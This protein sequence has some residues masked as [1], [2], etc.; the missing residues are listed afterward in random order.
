MQGNI[1]KSTDICNELIPVN[2]GF[3]VKNIY[4]KKIFQIKNRKID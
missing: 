2:I 1:R 4:S 3:D